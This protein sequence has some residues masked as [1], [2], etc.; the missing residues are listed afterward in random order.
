MKRLAVCVLLASALGCGTKPPAI[1]P[2]PFTPLIVGNYWEV[3]GRD[4][5]PDPKAHEAE[6]YA[7]LRRVCHEK[8][9]K[10]EVFCF[11]GDGCNAAAWDARYDFTD[12]TKHTY[13]EGHTVD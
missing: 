2:N 4:V 7:E 12:G 3:P 1:T 9:L 6:V 8:H 10:Y 13:Y 5:A 11:L